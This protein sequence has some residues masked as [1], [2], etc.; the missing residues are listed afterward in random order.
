[1]D[2]DEARSIIRRELERYRA[3]AHA[4]LLCLVED[5]EDYEVNAPS[6]KA[7]QIKIFGI[8]DDEQHGH[9]RVMGAIDDGG[10]WTSFAPLCEDF[11]MRPDGSFVDE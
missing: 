8:V 7:Y 3:Q 6:G 10:W 1:M 4:D 5:S 11:I 9:L 2:K